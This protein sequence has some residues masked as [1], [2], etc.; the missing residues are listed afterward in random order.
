[1]RPRLPR[2]QS[3]FEPVLRTGPSVK[4]QALTAGKLA[5]G[6]AIEHSRV[7]TATFPAFATVKALMRHERGGTMVLTLGQECRAVAEE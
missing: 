1:V 2:L 3:C 7:S 4:P 5:G 6:L